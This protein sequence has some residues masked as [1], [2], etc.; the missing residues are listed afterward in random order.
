MNQE[1]INKLEQIKSSFL[2]F[3]ESNK[4]KQSV[5]LYE[6]KDKTLIELIEYFKK[7]NSF[8][9]TKE[10]IIN[11]ICN[12]VGIDQNNNELYSTLEKYVSL[13]YEITTLFE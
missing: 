7:Y 12:D 1:Q 4:T 2:E 6:M 11:E 13:F 9:H 5:Y 3:L 10:F 8:F